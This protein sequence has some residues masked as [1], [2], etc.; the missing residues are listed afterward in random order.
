MKNNPNILSE[1]SYPEAYAMLEQMKKEILNSGKVKYKAEFE[2]QLKIINEDVLNAFCAPGGYI[3]VYTGLMKY[4]DA[5]DDLA[6]VIGHEIA[7]ADKRH[8]TTQMTKTHGIG[9][10]TSI[11]L[12]EASQSTVAQMGQNL[13]N[14][15]FGR[16][17]ETESDK[18]SVEYLCN[19][20]FKPDG[21]AAFFEKLNTQGAGSKTP[22]FLSTHPNPERRVEA[23]K[24]YATSLGCNM[25]K[26]S[27]LN[28]KKVVSTLP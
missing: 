20:S 7:H 15:K 13:I 3:Y 21:A 18:S 4:L 14:L 12:G 1:A 9:V 24:E 16:G 26:K 23:I 11:A 5:A 25:N 10:L 2:W 6:G 17:D 8:S 19:S 28:Y 27:T 22:E